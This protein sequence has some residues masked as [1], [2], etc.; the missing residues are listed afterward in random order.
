M[1]IFG[2]ARWGMIGQ[3]MGEAELR[4]RAAPGYVDDILDR[5]QLLM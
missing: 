2:D 3:R 5:A 4:G 1:L